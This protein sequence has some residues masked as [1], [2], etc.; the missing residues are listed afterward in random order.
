MLDFNIKN[1]LKEVFLL[2]LNIKDL[3]KDGL[4]GEFLYH[5]TAFLEMQTFLSFMC[6]DDPGCKQVHIVNGQLGAQ[7]R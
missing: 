7:Y 6:L 1:L 5:I 4:K 2:F 3:D